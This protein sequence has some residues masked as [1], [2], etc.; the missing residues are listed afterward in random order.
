M[1]Q[2]LKLDWETEPIIG[3]LS[4]YEIYLRNKGM[5]KSTID[6]CVLRIS[7]YLEYCGTAKPSP[8]STYKFREHLFKKNL[9]N[10]SVSNYS[11]AM[12]NYHA[13][14]GEDVKF[15][16]L[17]R[18]NVIPYFFTADEVSRI[19][20]CI[21][22]LKH[23]AMFECAFYACLR[24]SELCNLNVEDLDLDNFKLVVRDGKMGKSD[25]CFLQEPA[26]DVLRKYLEFR[27]N[28][29]IDNQYPLFYTDW[30][31][32]FNRKNI[33]HLVMFYKKRAGITK[34]GN[35]HVLFRHTL[36]SLMIKNGCD[37][38]TIKDTLRHSS[39]ESTMRYLHM[40]D[41]TRREKYNEFLR[42]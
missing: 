5:R 41:D 11:F 3:S 29:R 24:A 16:S 26:I 9:S 38:L 34:P 10:S 6:N 8:E 13:M 15:P 30:G 22:N 14:L 27:P 35:C 36:A 28:L 7:K 1:R 40:C 4:N 32:R 21:R 12:R 25:V 17:P 20:N 37:L 31:A 39:I 23:I 33:Y 42:L 2:K 19:F 18:R